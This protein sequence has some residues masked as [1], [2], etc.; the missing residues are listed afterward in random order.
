MPDFIQNLNSTPQPAAPSYLE[1]PYDGQ[2]NYNACRDPWRIGIE[3]L[4]SADP[5]AK[6]AADAI[7][8]W[9]RNKTGNDPAAIHAGYYL[10]GADLPD[11]D[12]IS[13]AFVAPLGVSAMVD[14]SNQAW[15]NSVWNLVVN[16]PLDAY[17]EDTLKLLAMLVMSGNWWS[18]SSSS[19]YLLWTK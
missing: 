6:A 8:T 12:Y 15:L 9:I 3:Y 18:P 7:N 17:Y 2:Y 1:G 5:R 19:S 14:S 11:N 13:M 10:N 16:Q 4:L